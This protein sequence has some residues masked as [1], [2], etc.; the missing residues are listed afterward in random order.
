MELENF[1][2]EG[3]RAGDGLRL[4]WLSGVS[5]PGR[6]LTEAGSDRAGAAVGVLARDPVR[7]TATGFSIRHASGGESDAAFGVWGALVPGAVRRLP[8]GASGAGCGRRTDAETDAEK[9]Y[10]SS[11]Q[12]RLPDR[13]TVGVGSG[14]PRMGDRYNSV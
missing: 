13:A 11:R 6:A 3:G 2:T 1:S 12:R 8:E 4:K 9:D 10:L 14:K 7:A 5:A